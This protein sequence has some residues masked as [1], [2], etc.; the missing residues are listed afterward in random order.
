[1]RVFENSSFLSLLFLTLT[2]C[3][4][5]P[6]V[7]AQEISYFAQMNTIVSKGDNAPFWLVANRQGLLSLENFNGYARYGMKID[8]SL[9]KENVWKYSTGIDL[10][11]GYNMERSVSVNQLYAE[12]SWKW[13]TLSLGMKH[14]SG[15]MRSFSDVKYCNTSE[16]SIVKPYFPHLYN[17]ILTDIGSG[18]LLF[19]GN[20]SPIPQFRVEVPEYISI[21]GR[22]T[23]IKLR[24]HIAYGMFLDHNFQEDFTTKKPDARYAKK[25]MYHSKALFMKFGKPEKFPLEVEGGLEMYSQFGGEIYTHEKGKYLSMPNGLKDYFKAFIPGSG[26]GSTP[27]P[28]QTNMSGNHIGNWHLAFTLHTKPVDVR[29]YGEHMFEDFSQL[30]FFEYQSNREGNKDVVY[31]PW[32]DIMIGISIKNKSNI[33]KFISNISYEYMSTYDQ[34]GACYNDPGPHYKEQM[35]GVDNYYNHSIYPGWHNYGMGIGNPLVISPIYN[36]NGSLVFHANRLKSHH[37]GMNGSFGRKNVL[38]YRFMCTYSENWGTYQ[39]PYPEKK[40]TTSVLADLVYAP[41]KSNWLF[42]ISLA[43]DKSNVIGDN[44]GAMLSVARI[45]IFK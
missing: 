28:E 7:D 2:A 17:S 42:S 12:A 23:W 1:M 39:N 9:G 5:L 45:G 11:A 36:S 44:F 19:S 18:G 32:R 34:S 10:S 15:E 38:M 4:G 21:F 25:V 26:E 31:Y 22:D 8:G 37:F 16:N 33:L 24:G 20:S 40:Y 13:L 14:R 6:E 41:S 35:D 27:V 29:L 30:F 3:L 43:K